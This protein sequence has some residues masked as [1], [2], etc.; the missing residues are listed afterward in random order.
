MKS[1]LPKTPSTAYE[2]T[3]YVMGEAA[4]FCVG[5]MTVL[6]HVTA[7]SASARILSESVDSLLGGEMLNVT[8]EKIG[9]IPFLNSHVD[10]VAALI[11]VC[12]IA[13]A[14][15][16]SRDWSMH[17][18]LALTNVATVV[19]V[20]VVLTVGIANSR[21]HNWEPFVGFFSHGLNGVGINSKR[22]NTHLYFFMSSF[23]NLPSG[24]P[25]SWQFC[26]TLKKIVC[27]IVYVKCQH[28][29]LL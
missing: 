28:W 23:V 19:V 25:R 15:M 17:L 1:S 8:L 11:V 21:L 16:W 24:K 26:L 7:A 4:A 5:W 6:R 20:V 29:L 22:T 14:T 10:P 13:M 12:F 27:S 2:Y 3:Y 9:D 18:V